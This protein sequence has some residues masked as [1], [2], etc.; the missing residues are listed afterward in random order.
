M[1]TITQQEHA[2]TESYELADASKQGPS[3]DDVPEPATRLPEAGEEEGLDKRTLLKLVAAGFSFFISGVNDGS[4]GPLL[5]YMIR[6]YDISTAVVSIVYGANFLG[7]FLAALTNTYLGQKF[8]LGGLLT[9]GA[10]FQ[11]LAHALRVWRA[12]FPLFVVTF[13]LVCLGQAYQDAGANAYVASVKAAHRWL[14][15]IHALYMAG[16]LVAP[17][18]ATPI[19]SAG[20]GGGEASSR[21]YLFYIFPLAIGAVNLALT[22]YAFRDTIKLGREPGS[23]EQGGPQSQTD[24]GEEKK[25]KTKSASQLV[26]LTL[27]TKSLWMISLF[28]FFLLGATITA[29]GWIVEYLVEIRHGNLGQMGYVPAGFN[30]GAMLGRLL[31][32]EPTYRLGERRMVLVYVVLCIAF[33]LVFWLYAFPPTRSRDRSSPWVVPPAD[34]VFHSVPNII[35]ASV[36]VSF[37]GFF[38]GPFFATGISVGSKLF[39]PEIQPT[40]LSFVF[41]FG[42][43]GGSIFPVITGILASRNGAGILQPVLVALIAGTGISWLLVPKPKQSGFIAPRIMSPAIPERCTVLVIGGGP[44]GSYAASALAREGIDVVVLEGDKFPRYHI[45][46]SMLAS[47]RHMLRFIDLEA[48]FDSYGFIKKARET[49][50][51][52]P[53]PF[54][55]PGAA[56]KLNKEKR[57]GYTDFLAAGGPGNYAWNVVRSEA[58]Q[59][60]FQ[61]AGECGARVF[62]AVKVKSIRFEDATTVP[63][64][65]PNLRPGRPVAAVY[66]VTET[67]ETGEIAFDYVVDAS[68]RAGLLSTKY[69][70]NRRYNQGLKNV[71]NWGY[72]EGCNQYAPGTPREN[73]P[74][75]E[76]LTDESGWA[77]FIP[78]HNGKASVG[79]V[80]NQKLAAHKKQQQGG[81]GGSTAF[82]H[83][84]LKLAP[85]L[86]S[87]LVGDGRLVSDVKSA[88]DYSY[89]ASS[90]AFPH[91]RVVGDAGCF[92]DPFFSSGVHIALTGALSAATTIAASI[93]GDSDEAAAAEWHSKKVAA[94]Y[95]RFL[96]VVLSAYKQMRFQGDPVL[97]DF[98]EDN[99]DRA[100]SFFRPIIQGTADAANG[101]L[102]QD[103][104]N[105]TLEFC[106][107]AFEPVSPEADKEKVMKAVSGLSA[108]AAAAAA[109]APAGSEFNPDLSVEEQ[110]A[111]KHIR[112]RT[113][114]RTEDTF[115]INTFG[116]DAIVGYVPNLV[117]GSLGLKKAEETNGVVVVA[118]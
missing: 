1:A 112:A 111:V 89:S 61:H 17:F 117:R 20:G 18:V 107:H 59:L 93:R 37:V 65:E 56:F 14:A 70:K 39:S 95:T 66:E 51:D 58:D 101:N 22:F 115:N 28:F 86:R 100:F 64:G 72:W 87:V 25:K 26:K 84:S 110:N 88:S 106:A 55:P 98:D 3:R 63:E 79:V 73:S 47:M 11:L 41:V 45:G 9:F 103:E 31:L 109:T 91:A 29:S 67:K 36:A 82:Y 7:W 19:A 80:M 8:N 21:W 34:E 4:V 116:T 32:A 53:P 83:E 13:W 52:G 35:A 54:S 92:I 49:M 99:F 5:P 94:A 12:P 38:S 102:S 104:L 74:F 50:D 69:M 40:A 30:G 96:L 48:K 43:V 10:F 90:Y 85:E 46:E 75:F 97:S 6:D 105:K 114:M 33:Q 16:C 118:A 81:P 42:Q 78:L 77:W 60:M 76:A 108:A 2:L 113:M 24:A 23:P 62:D 57:P 68:G 27:M 71:A 44:G 15:F